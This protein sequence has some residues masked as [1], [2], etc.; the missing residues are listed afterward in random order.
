MQTIPEDDWFCDKCKPKLKAKSPKKNRTIYVEEFE[1]E[2]TEE[3][4]EDEEEEE[5]EVED[6]PPEENEEA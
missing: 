4:D 2:A 5:M 6:A 3:E 1:D